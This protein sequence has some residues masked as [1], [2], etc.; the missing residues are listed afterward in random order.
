VGAGQ[1]HDGSPTL[2]R[3]D[4]AKG[5][6]KGNVCVISKKAN[7]M[8][9]NATPE[10]VRKLSEYVNDCDWWGMITEAA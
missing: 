9:N 5:Y 8:K 7:T 4:N 10:E 6:V 3:I 1:V 2:D